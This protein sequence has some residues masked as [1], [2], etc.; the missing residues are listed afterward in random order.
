MANIPTRL[1]N[2]GD[3]KDPKTGVFRTFPN[4]QEGF[5]ALKDDLNIKITGKSKTGVTPN[6]DLQHFASIYAPASDN[7]DPTGYAQKLATKLNVPVNTPIS[8]LQNRVDDFASAI[9]DNEGY[10][11]PRVL[12]TTQTASA[13]QSI[14]QPT[15]QRY[16]LQ[17]FGKTIQNK[18]PQYAGMDPAVVAQKT[19]EK[20][21]Q[22]KSR[23]DDQSGAPQQSGPV[24]SFDNTQ[25][26]LQKTPVQK[27]EEK[28][29]FF[30]RAVRAVANPYLKGASSVAGIYDAVTG[31]GDK[32][33]KITN[34]GID[35]GYFGK[36][37]PVG[38]GFDIRKPLSQNVAPLMDSVKVGSRVASDIL[39]TQSVLGAAKSL[40]G[41]GSALTPASGI[42]NDLT[43]LTPEKFAS[44]GSSGQLDILSEALKSSTSA[45]DKLILQKAIE[46]IAPK[47][48]IESGVGSAAELHPLMHAVPNA[49]GNAGKFI[50]KNILGIGNLGLTSGLI[51][52][53]LKKNQEGSR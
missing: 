40:F 38:A 43:G 52:S 28:P 11:G 17:E 33:D 18:Y 50:G 44:A 53:L 32:A 42:V 4:P 8:A 22:Y 24:T 49:L 21:P 13:A 7:N 51:Y 6:S 9:A 27:T 37:K 35:Y 12:G 14:E 48:L 31:K 47:A 39:L 34:E 23:I 25:I 46:E 26:P 3:L 5:K 41:A 29:G 36:V 30:K 15:S 2:P 1:N 16:S 19:L 45:S 10:Q 20:Y